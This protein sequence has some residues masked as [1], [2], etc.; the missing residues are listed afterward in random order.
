MKRGSYEQRLPCGRCVSAPEASCDKA[1][2]GRRKTAKP[3]LGSVHNVVHRREA[4]LGGDASVPAACCWL[5]G[6]HCLCK[7]SGS[8]NGNGPAGLVCQQQQAQGSTCY[9]TS[10]LVANGCAQPLPPTM[11]D[12]PTCSTI[13]V[14]RSTGAPPWK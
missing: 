4:G 6:V 2:A 12:D 1:G 5:V 13:W 9:T 14:L 7:A 3:Q 10:K 11:T 8:T